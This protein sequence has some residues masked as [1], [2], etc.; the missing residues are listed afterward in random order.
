MSWLAENAYLE[1]AR[2][3]LRDG[4]HME[5]RNGFVKSLSNQI[6]KFDL[7]DGYFPL[8]TTRKMH[9]KGVLGE[10]AAMIRGPKH[11]DDFKRWGCNYWDD[12]A[13]EDGSIDVDY[14]NAWIDYN[15]TNQVAE[16]LA[17]MDYNP[18][19]RRMMITGWR[20][21]RVYDGSLSLP[22]CHHT[23]QFYVSD[24]GHVDLLWHQRSADW[25]VGMPS[26]MVLAAL[27]LIHMSKAAMKK[28]RNVTMVIGNAHIYGEHLDNAAKQVK[29]NPWGPPEYKYRWRRHWQS[30]EPGDLELINYQH[31]DPIKYELKV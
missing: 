18:A 25:M 2:D 26:D 20:P 5:G 14:G 4:D 22:C 28:P 8:I 29:R 31:H 13:N 17:A 3:I 12:W 16:V 10:Y 11:V 19:S 1:I 27:M 7:S 15:G 21:D 23:Y 9:Y 30:F 24:D 6:L